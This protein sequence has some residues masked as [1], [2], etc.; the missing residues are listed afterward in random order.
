MIAAAVNPVLRSVCSAVGRI[1]K[2]AFGTIFLLCMVKRSIQCDMRVMFPCLSASLGFGRC[3]SARIILPAKIAV[4]WKLHEGLHHKVTSLP[5]LLCEGS[6][7]DKVKSLCNVDQEGG[8]I[9]LRVHIRLT[10]RSL[11]C[12]ILPRFRRANAVLAHH[13]SRALSAYRIQLAEC[14]HGR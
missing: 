10:V 6:G 5:S 13:S 12:I 4:H 11:A 7:T 8:L 2:D 14:W 1:L 3:S 9:S